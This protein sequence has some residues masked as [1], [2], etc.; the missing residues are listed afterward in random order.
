MPRGRRK[1][2]TLE[3]IEKVC[4][5]HYLSSSTMAQIARHFDVSEGV[6]RRVIKEHGRGYY[7]ARQEEIE[8]FRKRYHGW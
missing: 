3:E 2:D 6:V 5:L 4:N 7:S 8:E 1:L